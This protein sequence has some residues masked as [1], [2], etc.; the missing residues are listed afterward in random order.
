M[1]PK[2][3]SDSTDPSGDQNVTEQHLH[4]S[5]AAGLEPAVT[6]TDVGDD[7]PLPLAG[8]I[9]S[10]PTDIGNTG[11]PASLVAQPLR[12]ALFRRNFADADTPESPISGHAISHDGLGKVTEPRSRACR[13]AR[14]FEDA[15]ESSVRQLQSVIWC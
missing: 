6:K 15:T 3:W 10:K 13:S 2:L 1:I 14:S 9:K 5:R 4:G 11:D 8:V 12:Q 7:C